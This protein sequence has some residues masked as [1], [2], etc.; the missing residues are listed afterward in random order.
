[1]KYFNLAQWVPY[2]TLKPGAYQTLQFNTTN[3]LSTWIRLKNSKETPSAHMTPKGGFLQKKFTTAIV[4]YLFWP[5]T[6][7]I[8]VR[9][10]RVGAL[11]VTVG[12]EDIQV[13]L[14]NS[15]EST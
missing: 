5:N 1:M 14:D 12:L 10:R 15:F 13:L 4:M 9:K 11:F 3:H 2:A 8:S 6:Q 7:L